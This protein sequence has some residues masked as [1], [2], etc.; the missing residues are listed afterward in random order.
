M[1]LRSHVAVAAAVVEAGTAVLIGPLAWEPPDAANA[2]LKSRGE[3]SYF[4]RVYS[5]SLTIIP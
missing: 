5:L 2:A 4:F 3:K 1:Q